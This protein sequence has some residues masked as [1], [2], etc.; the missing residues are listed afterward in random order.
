MN[1]QLKIGRFVL[2]IWQDWSD[3]LFSNIKDKFPVVSFMIL[4]FEIDIDLELKEIDI[5]LSL[6]G[7]HSLFSYYY[8]KD[9]VQNHE[10][11]PS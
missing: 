11:L 5:S 2:T 4:G 1:N 9:L 6:L 3:I 7:I 10:N 8:G